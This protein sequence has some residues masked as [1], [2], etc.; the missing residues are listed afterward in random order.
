MGAYVGAKVSFSFLELEDWMAIVMLA[1]ATLF[2]TGLGLI[3]SIVVKTAEAASGLA[4]AIA[5]P[6]MFT[7]GIWWPPREMLPE[8]LKT[9][10]SYNPATLAI[11]AARAVL[12]FNEGL[13][14]IVQNLPIIAVGTVLIYVIGAIVYKIVLRKH[15]LM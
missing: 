6:M 10:A 8:P 7:S 5:F 3:L 2:F 4:M 11:D 1:L 15:A 12:V 13:D 14:V 9:F